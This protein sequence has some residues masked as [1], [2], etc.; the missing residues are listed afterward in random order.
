MRTY[1]LTPHKVVLVGE[2]G[3]QTV[4]NSDGSIRII[5][6][7]ETVTHL[8]GVP[9]IRKQQKGVTGIPE[10]LKDGDIV[11][12]SAVALPEATRSLP[13]VMVV[14]PD[15]G[16]ESVVRDAEGRIIGVRRWQCC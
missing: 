6:E 12:V 10:S 7:F 15:T 13:G 3:E 16:P 11:I 1:N 4:Y 8:E 5:E 9:V 14:S 2:N